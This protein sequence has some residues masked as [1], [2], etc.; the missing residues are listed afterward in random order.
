[1]DN[2]PA[3]HCTGL[4]KTYKV[5][6]WQR[7]VRGLTHLDLEVQPGEVFGFVGPN[8]AGKTTTLKILVGLQFQSHGKASIFGHP[9]GSE[10]ANALL[11]FLPERPY[12][13][14]HLTG[15]EL[16]RFYGHLFNRSGSELE[17]QIDALL[18]RVGLTSFQKVPLKA[19][20]KGMLQRAGLAQAL[21]NKPKV[22]LLDEPM[23][24]LDPMGRMLVRDIILEEKA[25]GTT[26]FFSSHILADV[27]QICD[28]VG[29]LVNGKMRACGPI[30]ELLSTAVAHL[31]CVIEGLT[32]QQLKA[33]GLEYE[34]LGQ[35][36]D[37]I[38]IRLSPKEVDALVDHV[39]TL[40]GHL[41]E[42]IPKRHHLEDLLAEQLGVESPSFNPKNAGVF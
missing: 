18:E 19:Y 23:S 32:I 4:S 3:I 22:I 25:K 34:A 13:Y 29:I 26:V 20:S 10:A 1:M 41:L 15:K 9:A 37:R 36:G 16:L 8:G 14:A 21:L 7:K 2:Q 39:R 27:E 28:R 35:D 5:G 6:F 12:F 38:R 11:G 24:G 40:G 17:K 31:D 30:R 42:L 33:S